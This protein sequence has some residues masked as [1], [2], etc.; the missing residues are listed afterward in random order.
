MCG[1]IQ[2]LVQDVE[3]NE[4]VWQKEEFTLSDTVN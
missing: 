4:E 2:V 3:L 1:G